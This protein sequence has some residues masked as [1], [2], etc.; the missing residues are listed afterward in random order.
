MKLWR[1]NFCL[2]VRQFRYLQLHTGQSLPG[3]LPP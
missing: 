2:H 3:Q 1:I